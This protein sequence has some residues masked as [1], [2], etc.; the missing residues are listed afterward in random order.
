MSKLSKTQKDV[1]PDKL[2]YISS[3]T[4]TY[5]LLHWRTS[6]KKA[7]RSSG[8]TR[9]YSVIDPTS[10]APCRSPPKAIFWAPIIGNTLGLKLRLSQSG[11]LP[12]H[13]GGTACRLWSLLK[14]CYLHH[15]KESTQTHYGH[16]EHKPVSSLHQQKASRSFYRFAE[17]I[18]NHK[19][20][21]CV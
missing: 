13:R 18:Y 17:N 5:N 21:F 4:T 8:L 3:V 7:T 16:T 6:L 20:T 15:R 11:C 19:Q 1:L 12:L 14:P 9:L 10:W 2:L